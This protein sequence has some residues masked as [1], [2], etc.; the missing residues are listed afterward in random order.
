MADEEIKNDSDV[1]G[2]TDSLKNQTSQKPDV[3]VTPE[4]EKK[5][6][7]TR[8]KK[9]PD[10]LPFDLEDAGS[11]VAIPFT[12]WG[13]P[14]TPDEQQRLG[15]VV[16]RWLDKRCGMLAE[17]SVDIALAI[18]LLEVILKRTDILSKLLTA[19]SPQ[20]DDNQESDAK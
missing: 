1:A 12:L 3:E 20:Q 15:H 10:T 19:P 18:C 13:K 9:E 2:V 4:D 6:R 11:L 17:Y 7:K 14:L 8:K 16:G 5:P